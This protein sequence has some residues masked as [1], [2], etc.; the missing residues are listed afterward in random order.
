MKN[1]D[2]LQVSLEPFS[3]ELMTVSPVRVLSSYNN[4]N[5]NNNERLNQFAPIGL[6]NMLNS[7]GAIESLVFDDKQSRVKI[8][9]KGCG[10]MRVFAS[11]EPIACKINGLG[12]KFDYEDNMVRVHVPWPTHEPKLS[13]LE[14]LF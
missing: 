4:Y 14:Y 10:E 9:I 13:M 2:K 6:V 7:G 3:F 8:G 1:S 12:V 11:K 5:Y